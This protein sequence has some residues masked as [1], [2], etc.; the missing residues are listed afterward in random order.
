M[1]DRTQQVVQLLDKHAST[2][3][4]LHL[5]LLLLLPTGQSAR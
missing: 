4:M 3:D 1:Q 2:A 5:L